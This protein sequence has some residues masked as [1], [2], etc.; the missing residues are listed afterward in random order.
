MGL[1]AG[2]NCAF[3]GAGLG[4]FGSSRLKMG[5]QGGNEGPIGVTPVTLARAPWVRLV[6]PLQESCN[7]ERGRWAVGP[8]VHWAHWAVGFIGALWPSR[9]RGLIGRAPKLVNEL[10]S[11]LSTKHKTPQWDLQNLQ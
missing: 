3:L 9:A 5:P 11:F 6:T 10:M 7:N 2:P 4:P 1:G 8:L